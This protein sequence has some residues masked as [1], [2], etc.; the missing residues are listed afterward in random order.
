MT[1]EELEVKWMDV[2]GGDDEDDEDWLPVGDGGGDGGETFDDDDC[3]WVDEEEIRNIVDESKI[4][5]VL[6]DYD[7][8]ET[9][10]QEGEL[11]QLKAKEK[12]L[13]ERQDKGYY[14][15]K[16]IHHDMYLRI[17]QAM[18]PYLTEHSLKML[19]HTWSTQKNEAMNKSVSAYAPKGKT[20]CTTDSLKARVSVAGAIQVKGYEYTWDNIFTRSNLKMNQSLQT[21]L[22]T[23][24]DRKG[25][26]REVAN[27][28]LGKRKRSAAKYE[29]Y[30]KALKDDMTAQRD[31]TN[32]GQGIAMKQAS[33]QAKTNRSATRRNP[34]GTSPSQMKCRFYHPEFCRVLGHATCNSKD[35]FMFKKSKAEKDKA[36]SVI[37]K[38]EFDKELSKIRK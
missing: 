36:E 38:A 27:T 18:Q 6:D 24:D 30:N 25:R 28:K 19:S 7:L 33:K 5:K 12:I 17:T 32:Y 14:R 13:M 22:Q 15:S 34:S 3:V 37:H 10:F 1:Y 2:V 23:M 29:K 4:S 21:V 8:D 20:F 35:C 26:K 11:E 16:T 9:V 31:G